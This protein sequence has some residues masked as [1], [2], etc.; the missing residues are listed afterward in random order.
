MKATGIQA[1]KTRIFVRHLKE[2]QRSGVI[3]TPP[4]SVR[5]RKEEGEAK[6][7][8]HLTGLAYVLS[9]G[10]DVKEVSPGD[11]VILHGEASGMGGFL[12]EEFDFL[13]AF[14]EEEEVVGVLRDY[15][16]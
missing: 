7:G 6:V 3:Y 16:E 11:Y 1:V 9:C 5:R 2:R 8:G 15:K 13:C 10:E 12:E 14:Y 4:A